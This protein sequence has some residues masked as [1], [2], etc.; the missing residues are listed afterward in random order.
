M[1]QIR[2][3][4][5][6]ALPLLLCLG[7]VVCSGGRS[8]KVPITTD[9]PQALEFYLQGRELTDR[10]RMTDARSY[11]ERAVAKDPDFALAHLALA[12]AAP[13]SQEFF[14]EMSKAVELSEK[15]SEGER[16]M[17]LAFY[18]GVIGEPAEQDRHLAALME[19][20][21]NDE[22]AVNLRANYHFGRQEYELAV[23]CYERAI[24]VNPEYSEP[25]NQLGY[26]YRF[27]GRFED[28]EA[29]FRKYI[30]LIPDEPNPYDSYAELLMKMGRFEESI[31]SYEKA[32]ALDP[33]FI[34]SYI[35][36]GHN[37]LLLDR[38]EE[39]RR[40]FRRLEDV[41]RTVQ[42]RRQA[43]LWTAASYLHEG[44]YGK[45]MREVEA[46]RRI[47]E[48]RNDVTRMSADLTRMGNILLESGDPDRALVRFRESVAIL[49]EAKVPL[50]VRQFRERATL[51]FEGRVAL[52]QGNIEIARHRARMY[53]VRVD[54]HQIPSEIRQLHEL[55]GRI[56]LYGEDYPRALEEFEMANAE[57]PRV[58]FLTAL[59]YRGQG[60]H[61]RARDYVKQAADF[62]SISFSYALVRDRARRMLSNG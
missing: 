54:A 31:A 37:N 28:A 15:V 18:S 10:L 33:H 53:A 25:Y 56:A 47:A 16:H 40:S 4:G 1:R 20:F 12:G 30:D 26:S 52:L 29:A 11:Y 8:D 59:A 62:N 38:P 42:E 17:I 61:D 3:I 44:R 6:S 43:R 58:L 32:L 14:G 36:I 13:T 39:A 51:Y 9:S 34:A 48:E 60:D 5:V 24:A 57:D 55:R 50:Q 27:A 7:L 41:S 49:E 19:L 35:G 46:M 22:R 21:P 2:Q 23:E 45:A